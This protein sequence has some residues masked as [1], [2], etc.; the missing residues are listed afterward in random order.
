LDSPATLSISVQKIVTKK[1]RVPH[2]FFKMEIGIETAQNNYL[3][4]LASLYVKG[5]YAEMTEFFIK[6]LVFF[7]EH[8]Y[9]SLGVQLQNNVNIFAENF[10]F[11]FSKP[12]FAI[13]SESAKTLILLSPA[14]TNLLAMSDFENTDHWIKIILPQKHNFLKLLILYNSR[15]TVKL[16]RK[17]FF[18]ISPEFATLW[19]GVY[20]TTSM[21]WQTP[22]IYENMKEHLDFWD[23]RILLSSEVVSYG[24]MISTYINPEMDRFHKRNFNEHVKK[25]FKEIRINNKPD[26]KKIAIISAFWRAGHVVYRNFRDLVE[27][28]KDDYELTLVRLQLTDEEDN[29]AVPDNCL[30]KNILSVK[31]IYAELLDFSALTGNDFFT[32][33]YLDVGMDPV[34]RFLSNIRIAPLQIMS[35]GHSVSSFGSEIDYFIGGIISEDPGNGQNYYDER[36]VLTQGAGVKINVPAVYREKEIKK[37]SERFIINCSWTLHKINYPMLEVLKEITA[38]A[39]KKILFRFFPSSPLVNNYFLPV[40]KDLEKILGREN[41]EIFSFIKLESFL[42]KCEECDIAI[43]SHP[44]GGL[45]SIVDYLVVKKPVISWEGWQFYNRLGSSILRKIGMAELVAAGREDY[46]TKVV[47]LINDDDYREK[48]TEKLKA[49]NLAKELA[50]LT[51]LKSFKKA[52]DF[53]VENGERLKTEKD[54]SPIIID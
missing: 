35:Y 14:I 36:L 29:S 5:A 34:S 27:V 12:D 16:N 19:Y 52:L 7:K 42:E 24:Y 41:L 53:L 4:E 39:G 30:F 45:N 25:H 15:N 47:R 22:L 31:L 23:E 32:V 13:N 20:F 51:D 9:L 18:D 33:F 6:T 3:R 11:Y 37:Q 28:L 54:R 46:I 38:K 2:F 48:V 50:D 44:F 21:S 10:L 43:D 8:P 1:R 49:I 40:K 17:A 26:K